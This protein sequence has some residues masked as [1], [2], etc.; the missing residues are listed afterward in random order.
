M[1]SKTLKQK[2]GPEPLPRK[3]YRCE[4]CGVDRIG[5]DN[6]RNAARFG[7]VCQPCSIVL[8]N[9]NRTKKSKE[10]KAQDRAAWYQKNKN[11]ADFR[12]KEW[13][14]RE[15]LLLISLFGGACVHCGE[16]DPIVLDFDHINND[17]HKESGKNIIFSVKQ[18]PSKFQLLCKNCNWKKEYWR[19][20][21]A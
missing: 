8:Y 2:F 11:A 14:Q 19:R 10:E 6:E 18:N 12:A 15:R 21:N 7:R 1:P 9:E 5:I 3:N 16:T 17:G 13:R 20:K 4:R